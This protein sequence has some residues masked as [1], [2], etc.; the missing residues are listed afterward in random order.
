VQKVHDFRLIVPVKGD[1]SAVYDGRCFAIIKWMTIRS[2]LLPC[3]ALTL[4]L[5]LACGKS[6]SVPQDASR[7]ALNGQDRPFEYDPQ[8]SP[9]DSSPS[10]P[11]AGTTLPEGTPIIIHM[12]KSISSVEAHAGDSFSGTLDDAIVL[13]GQTV[14]P[15]G[16]AVSGRVLAAKSATDRNPGYLRLALVSLNLAGTPTMIET[17]SL[18]VKGKGHG[19]GVVPGDTK[20]SE[21]SFLQDKG[22][23]TFGT[24]RKVT[25]RL[26]QPVDFH[27]ETLE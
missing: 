20:N 16:T 17:S 22:E 12:L 15:R 21:N 11:Q 5:A 23:V 26:A 14:V 25:F 8:A 4:V 2:S 19:K 7:T 27:S 9:T 18:F 1:F 6:P 13:Q 24:E 10:S 3:V